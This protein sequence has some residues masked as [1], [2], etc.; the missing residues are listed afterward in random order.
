MQGQQ[1]SPL[2]PLGLEQ[3]RRLARRL[4][5]VSFS[6]LYSSDLG[7]AYETARCV[8]ETTGHEIRC[9]TG[10]RERHFGI[11][12]GLTHRE[13]EA[14]HPEDYVLFARRDPHYAMAGGESASD[15]RGR[16]VGCLEAIAARHGGERVVVVTHGLVLDALY[17]TAMDMPLEVARG[18]PLL[19][20]SINVF[21]HGEGS[22]TAHRVC[23][24]DHLSD[25]DVTRFSDASV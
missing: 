14:R 25:E 10:L 2:T 11:F 6:A 4:K 20:C 12:E 13:I 18:F 3:A 7:R 21:L 23:D 22:W 19:N 5:G 24:V 1:D 17:R 15:F 9:E 16:C 8:A